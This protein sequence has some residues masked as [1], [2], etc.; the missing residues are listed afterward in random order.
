M[1]RYRADTRTLGMLTTYA[2]LAIA[3]FVVRP[4]GILA[5]AWVAVTACVSWFCAVIAHNVVHTPVFKNKK[6]NR[7][8]Q[9]WVSLSYGFP[10]SD[11]IPG[12]NLSHHRFMQKDQDVMRTTKVRFNW[13]LLNL[14]FFFVSVTPGILRGNARYKKLQGAHARAWRRQLLIETVCVWSVK[15]VATALDWRSAVMFLWIP[16]L[17]ANF[18]VVTINFFQHDGCDEDH[19]FNHSRNFVGPVLN[20]FAFNNGY[21]GIHH[22][23][24]GLHWSLAK[25]A[26]EKRVK[27]G[28]H[29]ALEQRS[30]P[31]YL[32]KTFVWP[33]KRVRFDGEPVVL[34]P[35]A[36]DRDWVKPEDA[37]YPEGAEAA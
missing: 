29:P 9:V 15:L 13:H 18:G 25:D 22:I 5:V 16:H 11:Y 14:F 26:H 24:P 35:E 37:G 27:P 33:G 1:L 34:P 32:F 8:L 12:H 19:P 21:H 4:T 36:P 7:A 2:V 30:L 17:W 6:L 23:E 20:W 28:L 10:I 3:G 31:A